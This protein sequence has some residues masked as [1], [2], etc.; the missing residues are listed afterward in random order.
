MFIRSYINLTCNIIL[1]KVLGLKWIK[2]MIAQ[3]EILKLL[4]LC[5]CSRLCVDFLLLLGAVKC[6][7]WL[8]C[9]GT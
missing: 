4:P 2:V 7:K 3:D 1:M 5:I 8:L 9:I 6:L